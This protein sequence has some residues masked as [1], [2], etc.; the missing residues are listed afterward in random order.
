M[1]NNEAK[2]NRETLDY[3]MSHSTREFERIQSNML[4]IEDKLDRL[5][6]KIAE[7]NMGRSKVDGMVVALAGVGGVL[8]SLIIPFLQK[9]LLGS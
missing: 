6:E 5:G 1:V 9:L 2:A 7:I 3:F 4:A 8:G